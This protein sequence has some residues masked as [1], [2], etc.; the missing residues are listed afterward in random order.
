MAQWKKKIYIFLILKS[1]T[2]RWSS[3]FYAKRTC[4]TSLL[5]SQVSM[6]A[7]ASFPVVPKWILM[8]LPLNQKH[9][10]E[11]RIKDSRFGVL[12]NSLSF[13]CH[14]QNEKSY[15][16]SQSWHFQKPQAVGW[17]R[18]FGPPDSPAATRWMTQIRFRKCS[19]TGSCHKFGLFLKTSCKLFIYCL[20]MKG[21]LDMFLVKLCKILILF[22]KTH[23]FDKTATNEKL[24][25][26]GKTAN[27]TNQCPLKQIFIFGRKIT[28]F[29]KLQLFEIKLK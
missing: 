19:W 17:P 29:A 24:R 11:F 8:N 23:K 5:Y 16:S 10:Y 26:C 2:M 14:L 22:H 20:D 7:E 27:F 1:S 4:S 28:N 21:S 3:L 18:L 25:L 9:V 15:R 13:I 6:S 12:I